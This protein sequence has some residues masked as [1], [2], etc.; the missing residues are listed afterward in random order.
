[1]PA[2]SRIAGSSATSFTG[3][4]WLRLLEHFQGCGHVFMQARPAMAA[5]GVDKVLQ[6]DATVLQTK[7]KRLPCSIQ[8]NCKQNANRF[9]PVCV[10]TPGSTG[11]V[12]NKSRD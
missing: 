10:V 11:G 12:A 3:L 4:D 1:M 7:G 5:R 2:Q 9:G 6:P 8:T